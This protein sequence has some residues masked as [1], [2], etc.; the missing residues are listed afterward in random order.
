MQVGKLKGFWV[1]VGQYLSSRADIMPP[2]WVDVLAELQDS[3]PPHPLE[4]VQSCIESELGRS[5]DE[6]F[7][8]FEDR[9]LATAS[10]AQV[11]RA[12]LRESGLQ[13]AVKVQHRGIKEIM[14]RDLKDLGVIVRAVARWEP[15]MD[16]RPVIDAWSEAS[17]R[18]LDFKIEADMTMQVRSNLEEA[19]VDVIVPKVYTE[20]SSTRVLMLEFIEGFKV[21]S[22]S[23]GAWEALLCWHSAWSCRVEAN[24]IPRCALTHPFLMDPVARLPTIRPS[25]ARGLIVADCSLACVKPMRTKSSLAVSST[26]IHTLAT[27]WSTLMRVGACDLFSWTLA[28]PWCSSQPHVARMPA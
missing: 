19:G 5:C 3:M 24:P 11:H 20:F 14:T 25:I 26:V 23:L 12:T 15:D 8:R 1:K 17:Q 10:I 22:V 7:S 16:F 18:E 28:C 2:E 27:F 13:V 4:E 21:S 9:A 6:L